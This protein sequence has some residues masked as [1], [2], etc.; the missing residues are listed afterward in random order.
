[1]DSQTSGSS[2]ASG[3]K[4]VTRKYLF[5]QMQS[6]DLPNFGEK[7]DY[8][9]NNLLECYGVTEES[10]KTLKHNFSYIKSQMKQRWL[11]AHKVE[12]VFLKNNQSW[13]EGTFE[14]P[15]ETPRQ[16][17]P[18]KSFADSSERSKRRKTEE[19]RSSTEPEVIVHAAQVVLQKDG[20]RDASTVLKDVTKS[21]T[22]ASKYR[23]AYSKASDMIAPL[24]P[25]QTLKMF[26]EADLT[27]QQYEIIRQNKN[28][29]H[30][31]VLYG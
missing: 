16:G 7:L 13:L 10:K 4:V 31:K 30:Q 28:A 12:E 11:K 15:I 25:F 27:R 17:R 23:K 3:F 21:P 5:D 29:I 9:E 20:K 14:I 18:C 26:V 19:I 22:R 2:S 6:Q 24:T 8:L 1:M